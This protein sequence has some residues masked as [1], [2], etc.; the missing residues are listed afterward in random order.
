V[1]KMNFEFGTFERERE[2]DD[3]KASDADRM[4]RRSWTRKRLSFTLFRS[5]SLSLSFA[6]R[7][8][9][10]LLRVPFKMTFGSF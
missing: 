7:L 3:V 9:T 4:K 5:P 6:A 2:R 1:V 10:G 8:K